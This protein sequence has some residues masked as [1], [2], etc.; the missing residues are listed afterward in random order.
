MQGHSISSNEIDSGLLSSLYDLVGKAD[1]WALFMD[2]LARAYGG[3]KSTLIIRN[4]GQVGLIKAA[5]Q[6]NQDN[7]ISFNQY[8]SA[9]NPWSKPMPGKDSIGV[10]VRGEQV[11]SRADLLKTEFYNDFLRP[12]QVDTVIGVTVHNDGLRCMVVNVLLPHVTAE[13]DPDTVGRL[14]RLVPHILRVLQ[15]NRQLAGLESR[16]ISAEAALEGLDTAMIVV[17][18][19][20]RV[21]YMNAA[22]ERIISAGDGLTVAR[23]ELDAVAPSEGKILRQLITLALQM[24]QSVIATPGGVMRVSR[25][26]GLT[27]YEVLVAPISGTTLGRDFDGPLATIFLRNPDV[28]IDT[29]AG[30]LQRLYT[31]TG[32][33][34]RLMQALLA[35]D[36]LDTIAKRFGVQSRDASVTIEGGIPQDR[37][38]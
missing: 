11:L 24:P 29:P 15:L 23:F 1:G 30:R 22:A 12:A 34:A 5:G 21:V 13:R 38:Q 26:S 10:V 17:N 19:A 16:I 32:A 14:Q 33:E 25:R 37:Y 31:L 36:T 35:G 18:A 27:P 2:A 6:F 20:Q 9:I 28:Q 8:Y 3:G 7:I 4:A